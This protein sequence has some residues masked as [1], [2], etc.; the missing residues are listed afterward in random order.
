MD[1]TKV[2]RPGFNQAGYQR[3]RVQLTFKCVTD[4][5][6]NNFLHQV[7]VDE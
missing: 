4:K 1:P 3:G 7:W 5:V 6:K 2:S